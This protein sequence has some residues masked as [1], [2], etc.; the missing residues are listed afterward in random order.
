MDVEETDLLLLGH[1]HAGVLVEL[2]EQPGGRGARGRDDQEVRQ[3]ALVARRARPDPGLVGRP[4]R[5]RIFTDRTVE[6]DHRPVVLRII[7]PLRGWPFADA[8][9]T[10]PPW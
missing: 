4:P 1:V 9:A 10:R 2:V 8:A 7:R 5:L 3:A 6:L